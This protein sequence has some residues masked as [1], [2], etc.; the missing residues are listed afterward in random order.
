MG[1]CMMKGDVLQHGAANGVRLHCLGEGMHV[2][3]ASI[4]GT[5]WCEVK[6]LLLR[7]CEAFFGSTLAS[8]SKDWEWRVLALCVL[9]MH[10]GGA[11]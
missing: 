11:L 5:G 3:H 8:L 2:A 1:Y 6:A 7:R 4:I 10:G 9:S